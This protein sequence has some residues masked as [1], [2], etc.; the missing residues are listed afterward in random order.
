[1]AEFEDNEKMEAVESQR[2]PE[3]VAAEGN[4]QVQNDARREELMADNVDG[5]FDVPPLEEAQSETSEID[6]Y[7]AEPPIVA[8]EEAPKGEVK[9]GIVL[10]IIGMAVG[11]NA[12][13]G[14]LFSYFDLKAMNLLQRYVEDGSSAGSPSQINATMWGIVGATFSSVMLGIAAIVL[15]A[16]A[17]SKFFRYQGEK[18]TKPRTLSFV[19]LSAGVLSVVFGIAILATVIPQVF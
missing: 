17:L 13:V 4:R 6:E 15:T 8:R 2:T 19:G 16:I 5:Y 14:I 3:D 9:P 11:L 18:S 12:I 10:S 1:M 7:F